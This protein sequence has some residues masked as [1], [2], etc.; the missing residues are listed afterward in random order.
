MA[1]GKAPYSLHKRPTNSKE[2]EKKRQGKRYR[3]TYYVQFRDQEG[4]YTS[5]IST[6]ETSEGAA[7][8][9]AL[10]YLQRGNVPTHRGNTFARYAA[11]WWIPGKCSY[12]KEQESSGYSKSPVYVDGSRR[13]LEKRIL[14]Y[15]GHKKLSSIRP[16]DI[17]NWKH[18]LLEKGDPE[19]GRPLAAATVNRALATLKVM[20]REA[21]RYGYLQSNPAADVGVLKEG[22][23]ARG[24]LT[25]KEAAELLDSHTIDTVWEGNYQ[26]YV[27]NLT[28]AQ[29]GM[30]LGEI[31]GL[32]T[33]AV[34]TG[35][36]EVK[37]TWNGPEYGLGDT[38]THESRTIPI[39]P[40][41]ESHLRSLIAMREDPGPWD[42]VF[43]RE[44]DGTPLSDKR[45]GVHLYT[46]ME[47]I[48]ISPEERSRRNIT[49]HSWR[50]FFNTAALNA[51]ISPVLVRKITGHKTEQMTAHYARPNVADLTSVTELQ[52]RITA[53]PQR[54]KG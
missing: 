26:M 40:K 6:G 11:D 4:N 23:K 39:S 42:L 53:K 54:K 35:E 38:K 31:L 30:R 29:T 44:K 50:A 1:R 17:I 5:A 16:K 41:L 2:A 9:W 14:P 46:A 43:A 37:H 34:R 8:A 36:L 3:Y 27:L 24:T 10:E 28:A 52:E 51:G 33:D 12:L 7:R 15:F 13:N 48:G 20:L 22:P 21:V 47:R 18:D 19:T 45:V 25:Q 32:T 49:F